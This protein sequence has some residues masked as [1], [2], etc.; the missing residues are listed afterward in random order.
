VR[1]ANLGGTGHGCTDSGPDLST[2]LLLGV[3]I[4]RESRQRSGGLDGSRSRPYESV[5]GSAGEAN[6]NTALVDEKIEL[7]SSKGLHP[8]VPFD[9]S[10]LG[11]HEDRLRRR[12]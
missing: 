5:S 4:V 12:P 7:S 10:L 8:Y 9:A 6:T 2:S 3:E 11:C 1:K